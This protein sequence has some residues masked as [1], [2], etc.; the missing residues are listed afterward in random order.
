MLPSVD[1]MILGRGVLPLSKQAKYL[2]DT[3]VISDAVN[4]DW[5][6]PEDYPHWISRHL[7]I[8]QEYS[9]LPTI[10]VQE[11]VYGI[12]RNALGQRR[13]ARIE[14][15]LQCLPKVDFD[16]EAARI[17]GELEAY[18]ASKGGKIKD[19]DVQIAAIA[20]RHNLTLVTNDEH[21]C[22][23]PNLRIK[24]WAEMPISA[25]E[26]FKEYIFGALS[27]TYFWVALI[28]VSLACLFTAS[29][30][31]NFNIVEW[32]PI[33]FLHVIIVS[34]GAGATIGFA[35]ILIVK[36]CIVIRQHRINLHIPANTV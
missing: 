5:K 3:N 1:L 13:K 25:E 7:R 28:I 4:A 2:L 14:R 16:D 36:M 10:A 30:C 6:K 22:R 21:F 32:L 24:N 11:V 18:L 19:A 8:E 12:H 29:Y 20:L 23:V 35:A 31:H 17:A 26:F 33:F 34:I 27:A 9:C 15:W